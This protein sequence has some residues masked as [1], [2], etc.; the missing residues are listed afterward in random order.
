MRSAVVAGVS[1]AGMGIF[2]VGVCYLAVTLLAVQGDPV[3]AEFRFRAFVA[4]FRVP[5]VL[6]W[7]A[8]LTGVLLTAI[9]LGTDWL[10]PGDVHSRTE[11]VA[12][13]ENQ[14]TR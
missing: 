6:A 3:Y 2:L 11:G 14:S 9:G 10:G 8:V 4:L 13:S 7:V 1:F 12:T 5:L